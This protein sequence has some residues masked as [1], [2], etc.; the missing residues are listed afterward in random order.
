[1]IS[2]PEAIERVRQSVARGEGR[3][4]LEQVLYLSRQTTQ[5]LQDEAIL[6]ARRFVDIQQRERKGLLTE[7]AAMVRYQQAAQGLLGMLGALEQELRTAR[8][9][10]RPVDPA[11]GEDAA[12]GAQAAP[13][14][15]VFI[16]H[17]SEDKAQVAEPLATML[18]EQGY[19]VWFDK[20]RLT[21]GDSLRGEIDKG[22]STSRFGV[23]VLSPSFFAKQWPVREL[24]ALLALEDASGRKRILPVWH[25]LDQ[26]ALARLSPLLAGRLGV[27]TSLGIPEVARQVIAAL[28]RGR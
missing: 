19:V 8:P 25:E 21:V 9:A 6:H 26:P 1:M 14:A 23:V 2:G 3:S 17:A 4:A 28:Q 20:F 27:P 22:L 18:G 5:D 15:D 16:S 24:E 13:A 7:E 12:A 11:S 10:P